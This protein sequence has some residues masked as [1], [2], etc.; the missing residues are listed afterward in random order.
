MNRALLGVALALASKVVFD[1][2]SE[3]DQAEIREAAA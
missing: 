2:F 3:E 1:T